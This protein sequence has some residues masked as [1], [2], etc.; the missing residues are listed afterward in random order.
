MPCIDI[1]HQVSYTLGSLFPILAMVENPNPPAYERVALNDDADDSEAAPLADGA[2]SVAP[3]PVS[4]SLRALN[5]LLYSVGGWRGSFRGISCAFAY[6]VAVSIAGSFIG[7]FPFVPSFVGT[8]LAGLAL[9]QLPAAWAHIVMTPSNPAPWYRRLPPLKRT[10]E[11][12]CFPT[13]A[14]WL[15]ST[16]AS[17]VPRGIA[18]LTHL[19]IWDPTD[20][21]DIPTYHWSDSWK[22]SLMAITS[23]AI[24]VFAFVPAYVVLV[25]VQASLLPP[26]E[27]TI[28]AIDRS[29]GNTVEPAIVGGKGFVTMKDA[30]RTVSRESWIRIYLLQ[31]KVFAVGVAVNIL[32]LAVLIPEVILMSKAAVPDKDL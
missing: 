21:N 9:V 17:E 13:L 5:R 12:T 18:Y 23:L 19:P 22:G 24:Y 14:V 25:R 31:A 1:S 26:E 11:A 7:A 10:F 32:M 2:E 4:A 27:D 20:P 15:A 30:I 28:V 8:L 29:F 16:L 3:K 6:A